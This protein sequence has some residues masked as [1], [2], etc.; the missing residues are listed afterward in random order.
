MMDEIG[1]NGFEKLQSHKEKK[2][3]NKL[4]NVSG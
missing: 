4:K 3:K 1:C 2:N